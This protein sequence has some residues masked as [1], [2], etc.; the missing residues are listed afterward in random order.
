MLSQEEKKKQPMGKIHGDD[1]MSSAKVSATSRLI[2]AIQSSNADE[3]LDALTDLL[4]LMG[5]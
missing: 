4:E 3:A 2:S 1:L 5:N